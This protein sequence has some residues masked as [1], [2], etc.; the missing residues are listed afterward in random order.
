[1]EAVKSRSLSEGLDDP[2]MA[3]AIV[4]SLRS[5][6]SATES[7]GKIERDYL[8]QIAWGEDNATK[9]FFRAEKL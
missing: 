1:M 6:L 4:K 3:L 2:Y 7:S 8:K 9:S 5:Y